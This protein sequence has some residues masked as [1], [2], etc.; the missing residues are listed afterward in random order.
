MTIKQMAIFERL[1]NRKVVLNKP[2]DDKIYA[3]AQGFD[4]E[5]ESR[6]LCMWMILLQSNLMVSLQLRYLA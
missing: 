5:S 3:T 1:F 6:H 2:H 4:H